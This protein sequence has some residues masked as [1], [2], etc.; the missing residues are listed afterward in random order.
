ML[1]QLKNA[2]LIE[3]TVSPDDGRRSELRLSETGRSRIAA[4]RLFSE[5]QEK[6]IAKGLTAAE[7]GQ[8]VKLLRKLQV[9]L[10]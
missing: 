5:A 8:L 4:A 6:R 10:R 1:R 3:R 9:T 2:G 7:R